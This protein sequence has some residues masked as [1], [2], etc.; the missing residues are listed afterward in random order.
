MVNGHGRS[1][2]DSKEFEAEEVLNCP[3]HELRVAAP[4]IP[5]SL[6][7]V[8]TRGLYYYVWRRSTR[9]SK[10]FEADCLAFHWFSVGVSQ[11]P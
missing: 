4:V 2:R 7:R 5:K 8:E 9:D 6:R 3:R 1:T 10:E 11:H